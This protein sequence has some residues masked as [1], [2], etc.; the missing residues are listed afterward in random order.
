MTSQITDTMMMIKPVQFR[1][2]EQTAV[3]NYYQKTIEELSAN[4]IQERVR[5]EF[6]VFVEKLL[7]I[8]VDVLVIEDTII[9]NTPDSIFP[10]NW[11]SF[12]ENGKV[13]LYPMFAEN[14]RM[15][16]EKGIIKILQTKY[17]FQIDE[18]CDFT[19]WENENKFLEGT[20]SLVLDRVNM[21]AYAAISERTNIELLK[22]FCKDLNYSCISFVANQTIAGQHLPIYH[23][24]VMMCVADEFVIVCLEAID[25]VDEREL[26]IESFEEYDKEVIEITEEQLSKFAGNMLQVKS[27]EGKKYLVMSSSAYKALEESQI[28]I[29]NKY[30]EI[31]HSPLDTIE[32]LGGG[33]ARC[34]MTEIFLPKK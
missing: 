31:I 23:T 12:H 8:G 5:I 15:E 28:E 32:T 22:L 4:Q 34:M 1:Y 7:N 30:C 2:N 9:P 3:N 18:I 29:I 17:N 33:S 21:M 19:H 24:N 26:L 11:V 14:R 27:K 16:R 13:V 6:D 20:G 25:K 10:N